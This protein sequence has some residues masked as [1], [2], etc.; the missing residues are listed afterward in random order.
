MVYTSDDSLFTGISSQDPLGMWSFVV[1]SYLLR[2]LSETL[3]LS[4]SSTYRDLATIYR[5]TCI[6]EQTEK[7]YPI[8]KLCSWSM[9][10]TWGGKPK[11]F[12][13]KLHNTSGLCCPFSR[14]GT[15]TRTKPNQTNQPNKQIN[16]HSGHLNTTEWW[17]KE[18]LS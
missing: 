6:R 3:K 18:N 14:A 10:W 16:M 13:G 11:I 5:D 4:F 12:P 1:I 2:V 9:G 17:P 7:G 8:I 15:H